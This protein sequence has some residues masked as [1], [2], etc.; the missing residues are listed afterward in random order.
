MAD[1][2]ICIYLYAYI[3]GVHKVTC[4]AMVIFLFTLGVMDIYG[5]DSLVIK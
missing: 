4:E 3:I 1:T 5:I 2:N